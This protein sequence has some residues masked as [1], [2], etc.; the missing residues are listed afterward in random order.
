M[1]CPQDL[2]ILPIPSPQNHGGEAT[3]QLGR[4]G[5]GQS[6]ATGG[7]LC[8]GRWIHP[9]SV[10]R[11]KWP[12]LLQSHRR[13]REGGLWHLKQELLYELNRGMGALH[14]GGQFRGA[15]FPHRRAWRRNRRT[16]AQ[17]RG[18]A[19]GMPFQRSVGSRGDAS[20]G[21][22]T[23]VGIGDLSRFAGSGAC[24]LRLMFVSNHFHN[25]FVKPDLADSP[26]PAR[27]SEACSKVNSPLSYPHVH[28]GGNRRRH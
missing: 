12:D 26:R 7:I 17:R 15:G 13:Q 3:N 5:G 23:W 14:R 27:K 6:Q 19:R 9:E 4:Y 10:R 2:V 1:I 18:Q 21:N 22:R 28:I 8:G 20:G 11:G 16:M 24:N 25:L